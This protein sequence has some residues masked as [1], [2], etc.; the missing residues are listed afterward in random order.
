MPQYGIK[1]LFK[2]TRFGGQS[3][4]I[5]EVI[6]LVKANTKREAFSK[7]KNRAKRQE[8][9]ATKKG[10][11]TIQLYKDIM[12]MYEVNELT[13][14]AKIGIEVFSYVHHYRRNIDKAAHE[15]LYQNNGGRFAPVHSVLYK[16]VIRSQLK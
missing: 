11:W 15:L 14:D 8:S 3:L 2:W 16:G 13:D 6:F 4:G 5:E 12:L 9:T 1:C 7:A 10:E